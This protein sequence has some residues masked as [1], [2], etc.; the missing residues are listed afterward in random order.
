MLFSVP[1]S[2][3]CLLVAF[4]YAQDVAR[5]LLAPV[6][7]PGS[8]LPIDGPLVSVL[9]PARDEAARI[10]PCLDGLRCQSYRRFEVVVVDD[11]STDGTADL[12]RSYAGRLPGLQVAVGAPLPQGWAGKCWA[13]W[14]AATLARGEWLLFLDA[15]VIPQRELLAAMVAHAEARQLDL[16]TLMPLQRLGSLAE[17]VVLPAFFELL[18]TLYPLDR[19][20]DPRSAVAF[21]NG[22]C[23]MIR[24]SAYDASDGHRAVRASIL[25]DIDLG[26]RVKAAGYRLAV[27]AALDLIAVRMYTGWLSIAEGLGKNAVAGYRSG[28]GRSRLVGLR[29]ALVAF[30]PWY[31]LGAGALLML[32]RPQM[33]IGGVLVAHGAALL[34]IALICWGWLYAR[35]YRLAAGWGAL[36]PL[37]TALYFGLAAWGWLR[38]RSGRGVPWKGRTFRM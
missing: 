9:I 23:L 33:A 13:C 38:V 24:R 25:E 30:T 28:G 6:L 35:R 17:R 12:V 5:E 20:S 11:D 31:L 3:L 21:A 18:S 19:V 22:P 34:P 29:Q 7:A 32:V 27:A 10:G 2:L 1:I 4:W 36:L 8:A 37:G 15:D 26:Q 14:Q 16:L